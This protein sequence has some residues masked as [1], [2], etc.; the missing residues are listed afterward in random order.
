MGDFCGSVAIS[1]KTAVVRAPG[2]PP[3]HAYVF[4]KT[5]SGWRQVA[6]L[7]GADVQGDDFG[8][9]VAIS[10]ATAIVGADISS[11][12]PGQAYVFTIGG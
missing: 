3:G 12:V 9:S 4:G 2:Y 6:E 1:G 5:A 11:K 8:A 10:G 7:K